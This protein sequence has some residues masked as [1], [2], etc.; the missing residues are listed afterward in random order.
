[1]KALAI[2]LIASALAFFSISNSSAADMDGVM[3]SGGRIVLMQNGKPSTVL[4]HEL[5]LQD[6]S[7]LKPDGTVLRKDGS[8]IHLQQGQV[9]MLDGHIM[10]GGKATPMCH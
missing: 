2:F 9:I 10:Q 5:T 1:M 6:G 8:V 7:T 4:E 3:M